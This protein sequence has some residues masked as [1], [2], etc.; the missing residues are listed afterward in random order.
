VLRALRSLQHERLVV[1]CSPWV[2][3]LAVVAA[4]LRAREPALAQFFYSASK[5]ARAREEAL[6]GFLARD[7]R[8]ALFLSQKAGGQGLSL[9]PARALVFVNLWPTHASHDQAVA[10]LAGPA[11]SIAVQVVYTG[12]SCGLMPA[13][14][15]VQAHDRADAAEVLAGEELRALS[16]PRI[17]R[18]CLPAPN[19]EF[20]AH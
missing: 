9:V 15:T 1:L 3:I 10:R 14:L 2:R 4:F 7:G 5:S 13:L 19:A 20:R 11:Q 17:L 18:L 8:A 12:A 16:D 6:A